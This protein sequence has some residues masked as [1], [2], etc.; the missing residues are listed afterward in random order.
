MDVLS[1]FIPPSTLFQII[2]TSDISSEYSYSN[3]H[4][5]MFKSLLNFYPSDADK[6]TAVVFF[7]YEI[8]RIV[9]FFTFENLEWKGL[10]YGVSFDLVVI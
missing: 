7:I 8:M 4:L 2:Q 5:Q 1:I 10:K 3:S 9:I 6:N